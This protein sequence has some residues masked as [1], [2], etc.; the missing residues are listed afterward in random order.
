MA[1]EQTSP[2]IA[3]LASELMHH[4]DPRVRRLAASALTQAPDRT[5]GL[6]PYPELLSEAERKALLNTAEELWR[7]LQENQLGGY[8]GIN[9]PFWILNYFKQMIEKYGRRD[10]GYRWTPNQL[11]AHPDHKAGDQV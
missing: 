2:E 9:R 4:D 11:K 10:T 8:S 5:D 1:D 6:R 3:T 7:D